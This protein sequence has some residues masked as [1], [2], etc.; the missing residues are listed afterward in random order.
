MATPVIQSF[1]TASADSAASVTVT[2]PVSLATGDLMVAMFFTYQGITN[3]SDEA[4]WT[5]IHTSKLSGSGADYKAYWKI[6]T[7][8]DVAAS[9]FTFDISGGSAD[10]LR[11]ILFRITGHSATAPIG[12]NYIATLSSTT[13]TPTFTPSFEP[14]TSD[15]LLLLG[16]FST[17][18]ASSG[19]TIS[20]YTISGTNPTWTERYED[21]ETT[22]HT[23]GIAT[24]TAPDGNAI[25]S[26]SATLSSTGGN[27]LV[28]LLSICA[29]TN[30]VATPNSVTLRIQQSAP[31]PIANTLV[32]PAS[33]SIRAQ[34]PA[35]TTRVVDNRW[36]SADKPTVDWR[37]ADK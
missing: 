30:V 15:A 27:H 17:N 23:L 8:G 31:T 32:T 12:N 33:I 26:V 25:T 11:I 4:G 7:A 18:M 20:G 13:T 24:A 35:P 36:S 29:D 14:K 10:S 3:I 1:Q 37:N 5:T 34:L 6:A 21:A 16:I 28:S 22:D 2:K 19:T 9:N